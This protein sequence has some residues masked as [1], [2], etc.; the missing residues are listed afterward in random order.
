MSGKDLFDAIGQTDEKTAA[1]NVSRF[2]KKPPNTKRS[3]TVSNIFNGVKIA[4][5]VV[6]IVG[7]AVFMWY[8]A[9][10]MKDPPI[11]PAGSDTE[12]QTTQ[13]LT[14]KTE[15]PT[16]E[17]VTDEP[18]TDDPVT[19]EPVA[20][21]TDAAVTDE[22][23]TEPE[24]TETQIADTEDPVQH[25][26]VTDKAASL[27]L[28][29]EEYLSQNFKKR[30]ESSKGVSEITVT[31]FDDPREAEGDFYGGWHI[32]A[33]SKIERNGENAYVTKYFA[34]AAEPDVAF[35]ADEEVEQ[36]GD[37][38]FR[39]NSGVLMSTVIGDKYYY[40]LK[41][42]YEAGVIND[43]DLYA[44][45]FC[46]GGDC[47]KLSYTAI[48]LNGKPTGLNAVH[49]KDMLMFPFVGL[50]DKMFGVKDEG[51]GIY[52]FTFKGKKY[53]IDAGVGSAGLVSDSKNILITPPGC[54]FSGS[55]VPPVYAAP[56]GELYVESNVLFASFFPFGEI[57]ITEQIPDA[58]GDIN[59]KIDLT[60]PTEVKVKSISVDCPSRLL[61]VGKS[62]KLTAVISPDNA[63]DK[64]VTW[65]IESGFQYA[66]LDPDGTVTGV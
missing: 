65:G 23:E 53:F 46:F 21:T 10:K 22:P 27:A 20:V 4:A 40:G 7:F 17:P 41:K 24:D 12:S 38:L 43:D 14:E 58:H 36:V 31:S 34:L 57:D 59:V 47:A 28:A 29:I 62:M 15:P 61:E 37:Y 32:Y 5:A 30:V 51:D 11:T 66:N 9:E 49:V 33:A 54:D 13:I 44:A 60:E 8:F 18:V 42:A 35:T 39:Y 3:E 2:N 1:D 55:I 16:D 48:R 63:S 64:T 26:P 50:M 25:P 19:D 56:E 6:L 45:G 52:T